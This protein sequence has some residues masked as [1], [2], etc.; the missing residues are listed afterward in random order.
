MNEQ[1]TSQ[2]VNTPA[3][4]P[5]RVSGRL[6]EARLV[7]VEGRIETLEVRVRQ[8]ASEEKSQERALVEVR[9]LKTELAECKQL[10]ASLE[11]KIEILGRGV[12][13]VRA[14]QLR[15]SERRAIGRAN[16]RF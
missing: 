13:E 16:S 11:H 1:R 10:V 15:L 12:L 6:I 4:S 9:Q 7:R 5:P 14:Y 3:S 2:T 8:K